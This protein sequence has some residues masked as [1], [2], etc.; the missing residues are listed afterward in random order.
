MKPRVLNSRLS[1]NLHVPLPNA[2][3]EFD[4]AALT[5]AFRTRKVDF[6]AVASLVNDHLSV[7]DR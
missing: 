7:N 6:D 5:D 4:A 1:E 3:G 2:K